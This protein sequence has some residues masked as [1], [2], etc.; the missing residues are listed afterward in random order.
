MADKPD[1]DN[2][3]KHTTSLSLTQ[4]ARE[5]LQDIADLYGM[6]SRSDFLERLTRGLIPGILCLLPVELTLVLDALKEAAKRREDA[7]RS[8]SAKP[9]G[10][11]DEEFIHRQDLDRAQL[12]WIIYRLSGKPMQAEQA[13]EEVDE[14]AGDTRPMVSKAR[15]RN[16]KRS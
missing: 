2:Q 5:K 4:V 1:Y 7:I 8:E 3:V 10:E 14:I 11:R 12:N 9:E 6:K 13:R 15:G 16:A